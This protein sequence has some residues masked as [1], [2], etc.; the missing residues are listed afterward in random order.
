MGWKGN[1]VAQTLTQIGALPQD[2]YAS[3]VYGSDPT[4]TLRR[5]RALG[6]TLLGQAHG[7]CLTTAL[8][9]ELGAKGP[10]FQDPFNILNS[11]IE[12]ITDTD[13]TTAPIRKD[14]AQ[15]ISLHASSTSQTVMEEGKRNLR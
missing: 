12:I 15:Y 13:I 5:R 7:R 4:T 11:W 8:Q 10:A 9:L 14:L 3:T 2:T 6:Q 1:D